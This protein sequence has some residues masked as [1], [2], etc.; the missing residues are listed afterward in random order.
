MKYGHPLAVLTVAFALVATPGRA[1]PQ[2]WRDVAPE[3]VALESRARNMP[4]GSRL[5]AIDIDARTG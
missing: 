4:A 3:T 2:D 5:V 1:T